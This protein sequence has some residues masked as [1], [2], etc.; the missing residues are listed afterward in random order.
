MKHRMKAALEAWWIL[1]IFDTRDHDV[2]NARPLWERLLL[3]H[4]EHGTW[5]CTEHP[6]AD[7]SEQTALLLIKSSHSDNDEIVSPLSCFSTDCLDGMN[8]ADESCSTFGVF[9]RKH[10]SRVLKDAGSIFEK[11]LFCSGKVTTV[12]RRSVDCGE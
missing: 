9:P 5:S 2:W 12:H 6:L 4:H 10:S 1:V 11:S 7:A 8:P 3:L